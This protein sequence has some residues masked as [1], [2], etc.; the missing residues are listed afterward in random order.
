MEDHNSTISQRDLI[1][2]YEALYITAVYTLFSRTH[3][4]FLREM[5]DL[6]KWRRYC[7]NVLKDS[8][9]L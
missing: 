4:T 6:K 2:T 9:S 7:I 3:G 8:I 5:E 1:D